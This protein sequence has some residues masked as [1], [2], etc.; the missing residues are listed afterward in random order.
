MVFFWAF[1]FSLHLIFH[2]EQ[3]KFVPK[4]SCTADISKKVT[5]LIIGEKL[6]SWEQ[7]FGFFRLTKRHFDMS[8]GNRFRFVGNE[9][10]WIILSTILHYWIM[11]SKSQ[12]DLKSDKNCGHRGHCTVFFGSGGMMAFSKLSL[13]LKSGENCGYESDFSVFDPPAGPLRHAMQ[14]SL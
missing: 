8:C 10:I 9:F 2:Y 6:W 5:G 11:H 7:I 4:Y 12:T 1:V 14:K 13:I 3:I